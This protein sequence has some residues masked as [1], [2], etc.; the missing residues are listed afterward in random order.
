MPRPRPSPRPWL[1]HYEPGVSHEAPAYQVPFHS[2]LEA[3]CAS[4]P[5]APAVAYAGASWTYSELDARVARAAG[6][7]QRTGVIQGDVVALV[8]PNCPALVVGAIAAMRLGA[9]ALVVDPTGVRGAAGRR[10]LA[11]ILA[12]HRPRVMIVGERAWPPTRCTRAWRATTASI[13]TGG[14]RPGRRHS[15]M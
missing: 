11:E 10:D 9:I 7:L 14:L 3:A 13:P 8:L 2:V 4:V 5:G 15:S 6:A 12:A 1:R